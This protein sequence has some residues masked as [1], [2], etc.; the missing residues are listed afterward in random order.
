MA[1]AEEPRYK[2]YARLLFDCG[3]QKP[4]DYGIP[5]E[6]LERAVKGT[7]ARVTLNRREAT[8]FVI[9]VVDESPYP[10]VLPLKEIVSSAPLPPDLLE[11]AIWMSRYYLTPLAKVLRTLSASASEQKGGDNLQS[12]IQRNMSI[13]LMRKELLELRERFPS[14]GAVLEEMLQ[15]K[16]GIFL[17]E[18]LE[19]TGVSQSPVATLVKKGV[20]TLEKCP[21]DLSQIRYDDY[22]KI[23]PKKLNEEQKEALDKLSKSILEARFEV[24]LLFGVTGSG[25]TEIYLQAIEQVLAQKKTVIVLVPEI[26]LTPQTIERFKSRFDEKLAVLHSRLS[27]SERSQYWKE[28]AEGKIP[29]VIGARSALFA[30]LPHLGLIIVDEEHDSAYKQHEKMPCYNARDLAT[31]RGQITGA[32]VLLASATPSLESY[33]NAL[34][35]KY[36]LSTLTRRAENSLAKVTL[37]DMRIE[38]ERNRGF[39][40]FSSALIDAIRKRFESGEQTILFLNRR[41]FHTSLFCLSCGHIFKC[42]RCDVA[43]TLHEKRDALVCHFCD[44]FQSAVSKAEE[45]RHRV[46]CPACKKCET[47]KYRGIG[48]ENVQSALSSLFPDI[49]SLRID[50]DT[51]RHK[52]SFDELYRHFRTGKADILIGTQMIAKGLHFPLVSLVG[53]LNSDGALHIPDFRASESVFQLITQVSGR[54]GRALDGEVI[55]QTHMP[56]NPIIQQAAKNDYE[57]FQQG[58]LASRKLFNFPPFSHLV[59]FQFSGKEP[60]R[61]EATARNFWQLLKEGLE[62]EGVRHILHPVQPSG[63]PKINEKYRFQFLLRTPSMLKASGPLS[64]L[65]ERIALPADVH[66]LVDVDPLYIF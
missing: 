62:R 61:T 43:L 60:K 13:A 27:D 48:T 53:I 31:V 14:Q 12:Y 44:Y 21:R 5:D 26:A 56:E 59:K 7:I 57:S 29:I 33:R 45:K 19:K 40:L 46:A 28:I 11:L 37:V 39:T 38:F 25:K 50:H 23:P 24:H 8:G 22:F 52:G 30:P 54:S 63:H 42:P 49:R 58:E 10:K 4:L 41:G 55:L 47:L 20:L 9:E 6:L 34:S 1:S 51:T 3:I 64:A 65:L 15:V 2:K 18:L 36:V 32:P 16:K 17:S 35:K 66:L